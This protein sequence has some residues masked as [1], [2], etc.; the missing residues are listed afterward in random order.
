MECGFECNLMIHCNLL[1]YVDGVCQLGI[2]RKFKLPS[3]KI[4]ASFL[5][6]I[7]AFLKIEKVIFHSKKKGSFCG[8]GRSSTEDGTYDIE[9]YWN[10][11]FSVKPFF[12]N[13]TFL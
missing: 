9:I 13:Q 5:V 6:V 3:L 11:T 12:N 4:K 8:R 7:E 10:G 1:R 2:R